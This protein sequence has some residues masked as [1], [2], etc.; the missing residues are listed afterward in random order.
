MSATAFT[1]MTRPGKPAERRLA[2]TLPPTFEGSREAPMTATHRGSKKAA[3]DGR[4]TGCSTSFRGNAPAQ[5][6]PGASPHDENWDRRSLEGSFGDATEEEARDAPR[7]TGAQG[8]NSCPLPTDDPE[9]LGQRHSDTDD[10][11]R[12]PARTPE[13]RGCG[14][15]LPSRH[16]HAGG[17]VRPDQACYAEPHGSRGERERGQPHRSEEH[18]S[19]LQ[20]RGHLVCRLL[21]E[22]KKTNDN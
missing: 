13:A 7:A 16:A 17:H 14:F 8:E 1:G 21:L 20:S 19:E 6:R 10:S 15:H 11:S 2:R 5:G 18:T 12:A 3:S 22:K 9:Q 4:V